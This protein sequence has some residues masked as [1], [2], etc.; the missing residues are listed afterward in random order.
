[1]KKLLFT[2]PLLLSALCFSCKDNSPIQKAVDDFRAG[3]ISEDSLLA[4]VSDSIRVKE[5]FD[6]A[7]RHQS[8]D[9]IADWFLGRAY[10]L[11][12]GIDRDPNKAKAYYIAACKVGN[13]SAM[14]G[15]AQI[16][17]AYPGQEELD[18]ALYWFN[19]AISHGQPDAYYHLSQVEVLRDTQ[20]GFP[21]DTAKVINYWQMGVKE[22]SP[23]CISAMASVYYTGE[24][25]DK[26]DKIKAY[27]MLSLLPKEKLNHFSNYLLGV[28]YELGEGTNQN[29]NAAFA[30]YKKS[31]ANIIAKTK[32]ATF[33]NETSKTSLF[34]LTLFSYS[35]DRLNTN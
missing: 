21:V 32:R 2:I 3:T 8:K 23:L 16:Y 28:M 5:T 14:S 29:F 15:L 20:K 13:G 34:S 17:M 33:Q 30:Y 18:S 11:G 10:K 6:W 12:L 7:T 9:D 19:T 31:A 35:F 1:M 24:G 26:P 25:I 4:Y 22:N 27:N